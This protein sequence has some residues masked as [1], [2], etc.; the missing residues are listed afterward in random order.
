LQDRRTVASPREGYTVQLFRQGRAKS[1]TVVQRRFRDKHSIRSVRI[2]I[3]KLF[4]E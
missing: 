4:L 1:L 3:I 2:R